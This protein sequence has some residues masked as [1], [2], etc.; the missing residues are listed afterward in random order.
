MVN[1][2]SFG[3]GM[4]S[5]SAILFLIFTTNLEPLLH[6]TLILANSACMVLNFYL[7]FREEKRC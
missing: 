4:F 5:F 2:L 6:L 1:G 3:L 7:A